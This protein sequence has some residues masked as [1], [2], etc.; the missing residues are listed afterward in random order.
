MTTSTSSFNQLF[1]YRLKSDCD[2]PDSVLD[3]LDGFSSS[4]CV[5]SVLWLLSDS[6]SDWT[7]ESLREFLDPDSVKS[8]KSLKSE[9]ESLSNEKISE[10]AYLIAESEGFPEGQNERFWN[11]AVLR[12]TPRKWQ[13]ESGQLL[14]D[15]YGDLNSVLSLAYAKA[16]SNCLSLSEYT[17]CSTNRSSEPTSYYDYVELHL[18]TQTQLEQLGL[19]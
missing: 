2:N 10:L 4:L 5:K 14:V 11:E 8:V 18:P 3:F 16:N 19:W 13:I 17:T 7:V 12:L 1:A 6:N 9:P 15:G